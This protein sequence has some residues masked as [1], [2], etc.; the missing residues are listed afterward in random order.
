MVIS[1]QIFQPKITLKELHYVYTNTQHYLFEGVSEKQVKV[2]YSCNYYPVKPYNPTYKLIEFEKI[3]ARNYFSFEFARALA[4]GY[5]QAT[6]SGVFGSDVSNFGSS[7]AAGAVSSLV[8]SGLQAAGLKGLPLLY[9]GG[10][11]SGG[12]AAAITGGDFLEGAA[13]GLIVTALNH[14]FHEAFDN[15]TSQG[16]QKQNQQKTEEQKKENNCKVSVKISNNVLQLGI[17]HKGTVEMGIGVELMGHEI[18]SISTNGINFDPTE[19]NSLTLDFKI[20]GFGIGAEVSKSYETYNS[21]SNGTKYTGNSTIKSGYNWNIGKS[22]I[23]GNIEYR[24]SLQ[25]I[26]NS[27]PTLD[28][29]IPFINFSIP[30]KYLDGLLRWQPGFFH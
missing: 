4:H 10:A 16:Q 21:F 15:L 8:G 19:T 26:N 30:V 20:A 9:F 29:K 18:N 27:C 23:S 5:S 22:V 2:Q 17:I 3:I 13:T 28:I 25:N 14:G 1:K 24:N 11:L 7:F 6:I 12:V